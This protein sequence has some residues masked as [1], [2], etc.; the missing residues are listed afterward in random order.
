MAKANYCNNHPHLTCCQNKTA[1]LYKKRPIGPA[2]PAHGVSRTIVWH[3]KVQ[4]LSHQNLKQRCTPRLRQFRLL[5]FG[6]ALEVLLHI[7]ACLPSVLR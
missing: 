3:P 6:P 1:P 7:F 5:A 2:L 4:I